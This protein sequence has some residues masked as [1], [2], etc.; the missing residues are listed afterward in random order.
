MKRRVGPERRNRLAGR[1][2]GHGRRRLF[3][4]EADDDPILLRHPAHVERQEGEEERIGLRLVV[5]DHDVREALAL[6][7]ERILL[8][9]MSIDM[10]REAVEINDG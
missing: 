10:M 6:G 3:G 5:R 2:L 9:N 4:A 1:R 8:D 7:V